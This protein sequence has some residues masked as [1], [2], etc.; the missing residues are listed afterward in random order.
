MQEKKEARKD[1][2]QS[3]AKVRE[4][5]QEARTKDLQVGANVNELREKYK[6]ECQFFDVGM[7]KVQGYIDGIAQCVEEKKEAEKKETNDK[8]GLR[9]R[10]IALLQNSGVPKGLSKVSR[11]NC[12]TL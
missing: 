5:G 8:K 9:D 12:M 11:D 10:T 1:E 4:T 2:Q 6:V 7:K 3:Q